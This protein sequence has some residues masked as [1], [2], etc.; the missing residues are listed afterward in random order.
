MVSK[1]IDRNNEKPIKKT[2]RLT[3]A[4]RE[5]LV[6]GIARTQEELCDALQTQSY[7]VNQSKI[8][9]LLRKIGATKVK[10]DQDQVVY[11]LPKEPAPLSTLSPLMNSILNIDMNENLIVIHT[12]PGAASMIARLLDYNKKKS[13][14]L[15][16]VAG[17][18][19]VFIAPQT[20]DQIQK[21]IAEVKTL[22]AIDK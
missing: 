7:T 17:D 3:N 6:E 16:T 11:R 15:G 1:V 13:G 19:T 18:D 20:V 4:L 8:S 22:L 2:Q 14:I 21:I 9:R 5:I 10:N 12:S